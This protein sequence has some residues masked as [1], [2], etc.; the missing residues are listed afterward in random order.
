MPLVACCAATRAGRTQSSTKANAAN[1]PKPRPLWRRVGTG[2]LCS[3]CMA[4]YFGTVTGSGGKQPPVFGSGVVP[5]GQ[6][7]P[8]DDICIGS[9]HLPSAVM[10]LV[11]SEHAVTH[12]PLR[13]ICPLPQ[14]TI[15][16]GGQI[17]NRLSGPCIGVLVP[18]QRQTV[19]F[20]PLTACVP[21][22]QSQVTTL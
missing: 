21:G 20:R 12:L 17:P 1:K 18:S 22:G 6:H 10:P 5:G 7:M 16:G 11:G 15:D 8:H 2:G 3:R 4:G 9:Q 13:S 14:P 19:V